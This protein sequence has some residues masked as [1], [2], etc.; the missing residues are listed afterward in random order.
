MEQTLRKRLLF[1]GSA[2]TADI[3]MKV[4]LHH[5]LAQHVYIHKD[6]LKYL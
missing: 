5:R 4:K 1:F 2:I 3:F 6:T